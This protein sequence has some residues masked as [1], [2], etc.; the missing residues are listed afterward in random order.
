MNSNQQHSDDA[1]GN[2][3][4]TS[5]DSTLAAWLGGLGL[6]PF[7]GAVVCIATSEAAHVGLLLFSSYSLAIA[8]FLAG[9]LWLSRP[10]NALLSLG[11][12]LLVL[13]AVGAFLL[14]TVR[15]VLGLTLQAL[16]Y[17]FALY[18]D[19]RAGRPAAYLNLRRRLSAAVIALHGL[20][21]YWLFL[22]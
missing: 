22:L 20:A 17:G 2:H 6:L 10:A 14:T 5:V 4:P 7:M 1:T 19:V 3:Q 16:C 15:P 11:S 13:F 21:I 18:A 12:N 8:A 9:S